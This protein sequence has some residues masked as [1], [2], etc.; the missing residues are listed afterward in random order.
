MKEPGLAHRLHHNPPKPEGLAVALLL[1]AALLRVTCLAL[2]L[3]LT[4]L[5]AG[6]LLGLLLLPPLTGFVLSTLLLSIPGRHCRH[7]SVSVD[8]KDRTGQGHS[9][10]LRA[11]NFAH[12]YKFQ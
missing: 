11:H 12:G 2:A 10:S 6:A 9:R 5:P 4:L 8:H 1:L 3:A 7:L